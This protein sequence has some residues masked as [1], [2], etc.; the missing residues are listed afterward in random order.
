M[1]SLVLTKIGEL[2][3]HDPDHGAGGMLAVVDRTG[4]DEAVGVVEH[5]GPVGARGN[6]QDVGV[7]MLRQR[8]VGEVLQ[9]DHHAGTAAGTQAD[10][11]R[12][13]ERRGRGL[14]ENKPQDIGGRVVGVRQGRASGTGRGGGPAPDGPDVPDPLSRGALPADAC[15]R[16][17][18]RHVAG[19]VGPRA[20]S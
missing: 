14:D 4:P 18:L 16:P 10:G 13:R 3:T 5:A 1:T 9:E 17:A 19:R 15:S 2:V 20:I 7:G 12:R 11:P 6:G 8:V